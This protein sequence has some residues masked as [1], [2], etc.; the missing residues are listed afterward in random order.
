MPEPHEV[1]AFPLTIF[2]APVGTAFPDI[3]EEPAVDWIKVG[4]EGPYNYED[5]GVT[6]TNSQTIETFTG[7]AGT[8][9]RK[10]W[11]TEEGL[12]IGFVLVDFSPT[13]F[14]LVRD[15]A[16]VTTVAAGVGVAGTKSISLKRGVEVHQYALL[17]RGESPVDNDLIMQYKLPT[18]IQQGEA[19]EVHVKG[20]PAGTQ[21][22]FMAL[23]VAVDDFGDLEI[24]TAE[25]TS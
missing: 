9:A 24:Q 22:E 20:T 12:L 10:A 15:N 6:V 21:L 16:T 23:E 19:E 17:A 8:I 13:Q 3:D 11:R 7:A 5:D 25:A 2:L 4:S 18:V 14:A 1:I